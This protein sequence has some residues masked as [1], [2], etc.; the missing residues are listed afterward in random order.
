MTDLLTSELKKPTEEDIGVVRVLLIAHREYFN[1]QTDSQI[2]THLI[3]IYYFSDLNYISCVV[4]F[5]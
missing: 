1:K 2:I 3:L 5:C 4:L